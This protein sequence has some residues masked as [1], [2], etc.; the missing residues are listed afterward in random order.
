MRGSEQS[1]TSGLLQLHTSCFSDVVRRGYATG[2]MWM[3]KDEAVGTPTLESPCRPAKKPAGERAA[4]SVV[5]LLA[6]D[7]STMP[8]VLRSAFRLTRAA[9]REHDADIVLSGACKR[10]GDA[11]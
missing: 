10:L 3:P 6:I 4:S 5:F 11:S 2:G 8:P 7:G 1:S 9:D